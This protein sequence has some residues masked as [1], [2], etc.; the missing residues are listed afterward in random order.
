MVARKLLTATTVGLAVGLL[1]QH[2]AG[3]EPQVVHKAPP[4]ATELVVD[5]QLF[6]NE[7]DGYV[8]ELNRQMRAT[9]NEELR[10]T[11]A[12]KVV[13]ASNELRTKS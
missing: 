6:R 8:R 4:A 11:L 12:P 13:I 1:A 10:R 9:L 7:I 3:A 5:A 2:A